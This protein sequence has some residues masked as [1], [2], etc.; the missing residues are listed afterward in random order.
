MYLKRIELHGFKTF[1]DLTE[2]ILSSGIT[3]VVGPNGCGKSNLMDAV[4]WVLG[5]QRARILR[6][7]KM[8]DVIFGGTPQRPGMSAAEVTLIVD[9][10]SGGLPTEF[11]EVSIT[12]RLD[13]SGES[14]YRLNGVPCRLKDIND[15]LLDTGMGSHG[16]AVIQAA[17]I[18]AILS[19]NPEERRFLFE[20]AAGV[21][22]YKVRQKAAIR[23]MEATE[24]D[25]LRLTDLKN[26]VAT[27]VRS[28]ARQKGM[29]ER[30]RQLRDKWKSV[31]LTLAVREY[32]LRLERAAALQTDHQTAR[33]Q[34]LTL[35]AQVDALE[36]EWQTLR[37]A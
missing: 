7:G 14:E 20:E 6:G 15:L 30:H 26:E 13:R 2:V 11:S 24:Q 8:E 34:S 3:S 36:I 32:K 4:R 31:D 12:R 16:Y 27:R 23:K 29:A 10:E 17:M 9:N 1:P 19:E 28:L 35:T 33:E 21:S 37:E 25:L 18:D 22:K 5:E